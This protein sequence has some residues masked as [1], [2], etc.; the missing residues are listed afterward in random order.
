MNLLG[1][2][3]RDIKD[4]M[5]KELREKIERENLNK[6]QSVNYIPYQY[7]LPYYPPPSSFYSS[8]NGNPNPNIPLVYYNTPVVTPN[9]S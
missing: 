4:K 9:Q 8:P 2:N 5:E 6:I 3:L 7:Y 1:R